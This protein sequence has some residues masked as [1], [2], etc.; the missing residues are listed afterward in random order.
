[1]SYDHSSTHTRQQF[2]PGLSVPSMYSMSPSTDRE[3]DSAT[4]DMFAHIRPHSVHSSSAGNPVRIPGPSDINTGG[5]PSDHRR[6]SAGAEAKAREAR[7]DR[8]TPDGRLHAVNITEGVE[9]DPE[10]PPPVLLAPPPAYSREA[11]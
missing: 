5:Q 9:V 1:M 10:H 4:N 3:S 8:T 11:Q 7:M 2:I 6:V